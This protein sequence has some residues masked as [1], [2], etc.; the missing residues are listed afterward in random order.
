DGAATL[1]TREKNG[2]PVALVYPYGA[3]YVMGTTIYA[4]W[5]LS[6]YQ[7][8]RDDH[9]TWRDMLLWGTLLPDSGAFADYRPTQAAS[10]PVPVYNASG[11]A[12]TSARLIL[13]NPD[14][15]IVEQRT[16]PAAIA[17]GGALTLTFDL[18]TGSALGV[19]AVDYVLLD[20]AGNAL[21][22][23]AIG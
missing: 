13:L 11:A 15:G 18:T 6:N 17:S 23:Q 20:A 21:Q 1:L 12:S 10:V 2:Y 4:D 22:D 7:H 14:K 5:G 16:V 8:T 9:R 3:G 19:W